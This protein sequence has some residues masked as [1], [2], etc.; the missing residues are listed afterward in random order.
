MIE[1][2]TDRIAALLAKAERTDNTAEA[3]AYTAKA[4]ELMIRHGIEQAMIAARRKGLGDTRTE[5]VTKHG[6]DYIG[7][8]ASERLHAG[9]LALHGLKTIEMIRSRT[10]EGYRMIV[11][12]F[13]SDLEVMIP[14]LKSL[15]VQ[16]AAAM[17]SWDGVDNPWLSSSDKKV[18]R[19]NFLRGFGEGA[20]RRVVAF[21][22]KAV[23]EA[24]AAEPGT[25][26]AV[27]DRGKQVQTWVRDNMSVRAG[28]AT[29]RRYSGSARSAGYGA[30]SRA[31]VGG[32][33]LSGRGAI[34]R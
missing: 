14:L 33:R 24:D 27:I 22:A 16:A 23:T 32:S 4:S 12:G 26:L 8:Y 5:Q 3:E 19:R 18:M 25:A 29:A 1:K 30:G 10:P 21:H 9:F 17:R 13:P 11:V 31:D 6:V 34:G 2:M 28:R 15:D 7:A 20:G